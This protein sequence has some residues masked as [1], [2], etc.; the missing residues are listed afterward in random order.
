MPYYTNNN[1]ILSLKY[2]FCLV[3]IVFFN[4]FYDV[5]AIR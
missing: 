4:N 5:N 3:C 1:T 2:K